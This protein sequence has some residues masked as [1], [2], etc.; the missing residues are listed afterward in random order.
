[1]VRR[2]REKRKKMEKKMKNVKINLACLPVF[3]TLCDIFIHF[4]DI[5]LRE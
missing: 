1:M 2:R 4:L 5:I 3:C